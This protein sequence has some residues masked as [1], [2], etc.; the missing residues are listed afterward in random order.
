MNRN[1]SC[2]FL[3]SQKG[4]MQLSNLQNVISDV[5]IALLPFIMDL[6]HYD[7]LTKIL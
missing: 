7:S 1:N 4:E 3:V 5:Y 6:I 2:Y